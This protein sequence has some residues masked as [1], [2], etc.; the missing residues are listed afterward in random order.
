ME[1]T[2]ELNLLIQQIW[3]KIHTSNK[4]VIISHTNSDGD[5]LGSQLALFYYLFETGK[6]ARIYSI[7]EPPYHYHFLEGIEKIEIY[8]AEQHK[9]NIDEADVV[10]ILDLNNLSRM[11]V[12]GE[13]VMSSKATKIL[14]DHHIDPKYKADLMLIDVDAS[15]TGELIWKVIKCDPHYKFSK[16]AATAL[17]TAILTDTGGFRFPRTDKEV[18][19]IAGE[20][21]EAGA[22]P[23][24]I[25]DSVYNQI[26]INA[27]RLLG[28][29]YAGAEDYYDGKLVIICITNEMFKMTNTKEQ[30]IEN[31]AEKILQVKGAKIGVLISEI[32]ERN[33]LRISFRAKS[34]FNVRDVAVKYGGGGHLEAAGARVYNQKIEYIKK[35]VI[36]DCYEVLQN[37]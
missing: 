12:L 28:S 35:K 21:V 3:Q 10:F 34:G 6:I 19:T 7:D 14:I 15:S 20:L 18:H 9:M 17:Y 1:N 11:Q 23:A 32:I 25:Y 26:P 22:D 33:E 13:A 27:L 5:S 24:F 8:Q 29:A 31:F 4:F 2:N 30:D 16:E 37:N 36:E